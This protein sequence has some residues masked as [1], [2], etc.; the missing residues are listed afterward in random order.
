MITFG[1]KDE[2]TLI[3]GNAN[4]KLSSSVKSMFIKNY[5]LYLLALPALLYLLIFVY[6]PMYGIQI[7]FKDFIAV[8]GIWGSPWVGFKHFER[9][10][11]SYQFWRLMK[12]TLGL[13]FYQL[14]AG[15]PIPIVFALMLNQA[16]NERFKKIVQTVTYAP[17]FI[18]IVVLTGMIYVFLSPRNGIVNQMLSVIGTSPIYFMGQPEWY[19]TIYVFSGV[20]QNTGWDAIIYLAA[21]SSIDQQLYEAA[22][23]D[24]ARKWHLI[25]HIDIPCLAPTVVI[26]LI[27]S[28]GNI[29]SVGFDKAYLM[30]N[31]LNISV[32]DVISTYTYKVGLINAQYSYSTAI[33]L[34]NTVINFILLLV[35]NTVARKTSETSLF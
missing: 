26:L 15:F 20:W 8:K 6:I 34:F 31:S 1:S 13:S 18:A 17:H 10:F 33:G 28:L 25:K 14:A 9:F 29:M 30:Q 16:R 21:L 27:L 22:K 7:A 23:V 19:Q 12:N 35:V 3:T 5:Q 32:A 2:M 11:D 24:G 4:N